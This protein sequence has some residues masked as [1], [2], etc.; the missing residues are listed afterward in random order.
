[1]GSDPVGDK[2]DHTSAVPTATTYPIYQSPLKSDSEGGGEVYLVGNEEELPD[3]TV[4]E[5]QWETDD[6]LT[7]VARLAR[8]AERGKRHNDL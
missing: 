3:K 5:I 6:E 4:E 1:M 7:H 2:A 8:E